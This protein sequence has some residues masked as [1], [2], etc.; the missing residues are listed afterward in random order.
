ME[1]KEDTLKIYAEGFSTKGD[2]YHTLERSVSSEFE[3]IDKIYE[4]N[5]LEGR[6]QDTIGSF[7]DLICRLRNEQE[8]VILG[9]DRE[10]QDTYD[11]LLKHGIDICAFAVKEK[12]REALLGKKVMCISE[13]MSSLHTPVFLNYKDKHGALGEKLTEYFDYRGYERNKQFFLLRDYVDIP[14]SNLVHILHG[15]SILLTGDQKLCQMLSDYL[16]S[17]EKGKIHIKYM[18]L[19]ETVTQKS[20]VL[21]LVI[22]DYHNDAEIVARKKKL[23]LEQSLSDMGFDN[24]TE[25]YINSHVFALIDI[26]LNQNIEKYSVS[27]LLP[28]GM[29]LGRIP[30]WSGNIFIK[31][32]LDGHSEILMISSFN[33][34][35]NNLFYYCIRLAGMDSADILQ[36]FWTMYNYESSSKEQDFPNVE[37]FNESMKKYLKLKKR[38]TSQELFVL[39]HIAYAEMIS[40]EVISDISEATIYW[41]PHLLSRD[42]FPFL[43]LWLEDEKIN[44]QTLVL[45]RNNIV[46][47]GSACARRAQGRPISNAYTTMFEDGFSNDKVSVQYHNWIEFK[48]RFEDIKLYP[49]EN[50]MKICERLGI[51]WSNSMLKTTCAGKILEYRGSVDF[52]LKPVF[53]RYDDFLSE[54]DCFRISLAC[55]PYQ[56]RFGYPYENCLKFTR[57]ELQELFIKPFLFDEIKVFGD[58]DRKQYLKI[59]EWMRWKLWEVRKHMIL[60]DIYP[61]FEKIQLKQ[62]AITVNLNE[63]EEKK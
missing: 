9:I 20:D 19:G 28:K 25:Y 3:C 1:E 36:E 6:I 53:N 60:N 45:R 49:K 57:N 41:E 2:L 63:F 54:F 35:N 43:A 31:G 55:S 21:C 56:K 30:G 40:G 7:D 18:T 44:G 37:K 4:A 13:A 24:Y 34:F 46:R 15:K 14:T 26:Y 23:L 39:F 58:W 22:P 11:L 12:R 47:T 51:A 52:D 33:D 48:M 61:E 5:V 29:L 17:V 38:F 32:V 42:E 8:I 10:A 62:H 27:E 50:L 16:Y 59:F